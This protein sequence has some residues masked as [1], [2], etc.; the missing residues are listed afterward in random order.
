MQGLWASFVSSTFKRDHVV[1]F[2]THVEDY[3]VLLSSWTSKTSWF[4]YEY[5]TLKYITTEEAYKD[6][7]IIWNIW[8]GCYLLYFLT[9]MNWPWNCKNAIN[10]IRQ[11]FPLFFCCSPFYTSFMCKFI[12]FIWDFSCFQ[13]WGC[14]AINVPLRTTFTVSHKGWIIVFSLLYISRIF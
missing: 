2:L 4:H 14:I 5:V 6:L 7:V 9:W 3:P 10:I 11:F 1:R 13:W 8:S 12:L